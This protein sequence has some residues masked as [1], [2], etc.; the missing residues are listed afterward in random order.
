MPEVGKEKTPKQALASLMR[1]CSRSE[2][3]I[4]DAR[5]LLRRWGISDADADAVVRKLVSERFIDENR[6]AA[7]YVRDKVSLSGWGVHKIRAALAAKGVAKD[8]VEQALSA[9]DRD[10][11]RGRLLARMERK[12]R[13]ISG[14][15][16]YE[17]KTKIIRYGLSLGFDYDEVLGAADKI[18][19]DEQDED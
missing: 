17:R 10:A 19:R 18:C 2:K 7:S 9:V 15:T 14:G 12:M 3:C 4:S 6:Y 5:R 1:L 8:A 13:S 11:D 16:V